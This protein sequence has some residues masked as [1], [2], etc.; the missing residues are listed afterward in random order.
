M[1]LGFTSSLYVIL[2]VKPVKP[3]TISSMYLMF[4]LLLVHFQV[5]TRASKMDLAR[6]SIVDE[7]LEV[8]YDTFVKPKAPVTNYVTQ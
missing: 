1:N 6:V 3:Y 8:V 5:Q 4:K 2:F 7:N